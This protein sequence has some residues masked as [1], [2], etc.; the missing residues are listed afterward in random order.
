[1]QRR[2]PTAKSLLRALRPSDAVARQ[3]L[4]LL[5]TRILED[6]EQEADEDHHD[7][8]QADIR[9]HAHRVHNPLVASGPVFVVAVVFSDVLVRQPARWIRPP[10]LLWWKAWWESVVPLKSH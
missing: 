6:A 1:M 5:T 2:R 8:E 7:H 4:A 3:A 10:V 9:V